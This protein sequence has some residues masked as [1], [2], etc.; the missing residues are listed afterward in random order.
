MQVKH[1]M[2]SNGTSKFRVEKTG[3]IRLIRMPENRPILIGRINSNAEVLFLTKNRRTDG[4]FSFTWAV[5]LEI[6]SNIESIKVVCIEIRDE[7][8][9]VEQF[10]ALK[11]SI[12]MN[13]MLIDDES[14]VRASHQVH[15]F[16]HHQDWTRVRGSEEILA[17]YNDAIAASKAGQGG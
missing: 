11:S 4:L 8:G 5:P 15:I 7:R 14:S 13:G 6:L 16:L 2:A 12:M 10:C 3:V 17:F 1:F 9:T